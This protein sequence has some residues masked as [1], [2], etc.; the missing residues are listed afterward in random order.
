MEQ[1][2]RN[3]EIELVRKAEI[4]Q[5]SEANRNAEASTSWAMRP[6]EVKT[7]GDEL[8]VDNQDEERQAHIDRL[9]ER[10]DDWYRRTACPQYLGGPPNRL[11]S[12]N[13]TL[14]IR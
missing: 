9:E 6:R 7:D 8:P 12:L 11:T 4:L 1:F 3:F 14:L 13:A 5:E 10:L 2:T